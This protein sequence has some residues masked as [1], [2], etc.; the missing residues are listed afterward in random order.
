MNELSEKAHFYLLF[1][2]N[3]FCPACGH[4]ETKVTDSRVNNQGTNIRRRRQCL[5]CGFR[6]STIEELIIL[7]LKIIKRDGCCEPY[8]REK[9]VCGLEKAL[10]KRPYSHESFQQL[11]NKIETNI[12][13]IQ[14]KSELSSQSLGEIVL[15]HLKKFD[16]IAYL[17]FAS[18]YKGFKDLRNFQMEVKKLLK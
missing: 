5:D 1:C 7:D 10:E 12:Q 2:N 3:M 4:Q 11:V 14:S 8:S 17:R 6:F 15:N 18:V 9:L 13:E 16:K